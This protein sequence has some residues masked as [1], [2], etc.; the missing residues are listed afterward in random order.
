MTRRL[1]VNCASEDTT[2]GHVWLH[3]KRW[4]LLVSSHKQRLNMLA[5]RVLGMADKAQSFVLAHDRSASS[6]Q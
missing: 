4:Q 3:R 1:V 6:F 5:A 2:K